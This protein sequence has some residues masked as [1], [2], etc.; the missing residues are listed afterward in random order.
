MYY[1]PTNFDLSDA[2]RKFTLD[3][4]QGRFKENF[5]HG[6][7]TLEFSPQRQAMWKTSIVGQEINGF[8]KQYGCDI[9]WGDILFFISNTKE[10]FLGNPHI[11][12]K[13]EENKDT[14]T[15]NPNSRIKTRFNI[16]ILGNPLDNMTWW[17]HMEFGDPRL[18]T[19]EFK[20]I[21]GETYFS[22]N[23]PG[24]SM[25]ERWDYLGEPTCVANNYLLPSAFVKTDCAH[26]VTCSPE[27]RLILTISL[28]KTIEEISNQLQT[29]NLHA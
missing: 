27:P 1:L 4:Y 22:K 21:T 11:D 17:G 25:R 12:S 8:L 3:Q 9:H 16:R 19:H 20:Y 24:D 10:P 29:N 28:D 14:F 7:D 18:I 13:L 15:H 6:E 26:T 2:A 5:Y 23:I